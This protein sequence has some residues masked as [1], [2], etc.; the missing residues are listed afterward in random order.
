MINNT[1]SFWIEN[2][3]LVYCIDYN[4]LSPSTTCIC[5]SLERHQ[6]FTVMYFWYTVPQVPPLLCLASA[7][8]ER[9][10]LLLRLTSHL[11]PQ[12]RKYNI[13]DAYKRTIGIMYSASHS[14]EDMMA[15]HQRIV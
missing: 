1:R 15:W 7:L 6:H 3:F 9:S 12:F 14:Q 2:R 10:S 4:L 13:Y 5:C 11:S 8:F